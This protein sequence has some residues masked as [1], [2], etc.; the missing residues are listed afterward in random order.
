MVLIKNNNLIKN[1][2]TIFSLNKKRKQKNNN[3]FF[4]ISK[5]V[6]LFKFKLVINL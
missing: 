4:W 6:L 5:S 2:T 3:K 1:P